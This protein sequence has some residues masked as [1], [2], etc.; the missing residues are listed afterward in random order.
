MGDPIGEWY[1]KKDE[2]AHRL[3]EL[4]RERTKEGAPEQELRRLRKKLEMAE[5]VG[6]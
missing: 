5:Y 2:E 3:R 1:R 4:I 6:D